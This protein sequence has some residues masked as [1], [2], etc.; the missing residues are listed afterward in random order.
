M[1]PPGRLGEADVVT[2][3]YLG[4]LD[5]EPSPTEVAL[6][7]NALTRGKPLDEIVR[8][9][10]SSSE[11]I[12]LVSRRGR[13]LPAATAGG[14]GITILDI[15]AQM[16]DNEDDAFRPLL[17]GGNC[18]VIGVEPLEN[19]HEARLTHDPDWTLLPYFI[20]DG[21]HR[22]F[23]E[24][25]S[26]GTSSIYEPNHDGIRDFAGL[27]EICT[28]AATSDV[29]TVRLDEVIDEPV[30]LLKLDVQGAELDVLRGAQRL[31]NTVLVIHAE[32]E[33]FPIYRGQPLFDAIFAFL[34]ERGFEL[35][36][37]PRQT[38]YSYQSTS[39]HPE[40]LLWSEAVFVPNRA[41]LDVLDEDDTR[42]LARIMHDNYGALGFS[43]WLLGRLATR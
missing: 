32:V 42:R 5:R 38:R 24:T 29:E 34:I 14:P 1:Q 3:L 10:A 22:T 23:Y 31:L 19:T 17:D 43:S 11:C 28:V 4:L 37:L 9:F 36:D 21:S 8:E 30:H 25:E 39:E 15:G 2:S 33:F 7:V 20:G 13:P 26:G 12:A 18:R 35:F 16:L 41:R 27:A 6:W 40:R